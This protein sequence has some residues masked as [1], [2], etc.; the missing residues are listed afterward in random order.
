MSLKEDL[1]DLKRYVK[2]EQDYFKQREEL[3]E[4]RIANYERTLKD[5]Q[6]SAI[7]RL[8]ALVG[9]VAEAETMERISSEL[10]LLHYL[11]ILALHVQILQIN[12]SVAIVKLEKSGDKQKKDLGKLNKMKKEIERFQQ[13]LKEQYET[14]KKVEESRT[15]KFILCS[16]VRKM[17]NLTS[18]V[19][20]SQE[21]I[22]IIEE[23]APLIAKAPIND[24]KLQRLVH[25]CILLCERLSFLDT[26]DLNEFLQ[27][28]YEFLDNLKI[29]IL[30][31]SKY[32]ESES[33]ETKK[34]KILIAKIDIVLAKLNAP[35]FLQSHKQALSDEFLH[36]DKPDEDFTE[37]NLES[38]QYQESARLFR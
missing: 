7:E 26:I 17:R 28:N 23:V 18:I 30:H 19:Q 35:P 13:L 9:R 5:K 6:A 15:K 2:S 25:E 11:H 4:K 10:V 37:P 1:E 29:I 31:M 36:G 16:L 21:V 33:A 24:S 22:D 32:H 38:E 20:I 14:Q 8:R 34:F 12:V 3:A 27:N